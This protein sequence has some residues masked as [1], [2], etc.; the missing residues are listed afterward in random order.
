M[1]QLRYLRSLRYLLRGANDSSQAQRKHSSASEAEAR[2]VRRR[3]S[4]KRSS[5]KRYTNLVLRAK[6]QVKSRSVN[7]EM[8]RSLARSSATSGAKAQSA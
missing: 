4:A 1:Q 2:L 5:A 3:S 8:R 7:A 6:V